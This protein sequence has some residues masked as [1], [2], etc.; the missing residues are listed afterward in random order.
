MR[1]LITYDGTLHAKTALR[2]GLG[3]VKEQGGEVIALFVFNPGLFIDYD[4]YPG[5]KETAR[6][7]SFRFVNEAKAMIQEAGDVKASVIVEDGDPEEETIRYARDRHAD[8]LFATPRFKSVIK[9]APCPVSVIPGHILVPVDN[10]EGVMAIMGRVIREARETESQVV[11]LGIVPE[12]IYSG[13]ERDELER[14]KKET[15][16]MV[17]MARKGFREAGIETKEIM[18]SGYPDEEMLKAAEEYTVSMILVPDG[19]DT[20]SE[21]N[22]AA[23]IILD[24]PDR[25]RRPVLIVPKSGTGQGF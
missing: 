22:K 12:H 9:H 4:A 13:G 8:I 11:L 20:P 23:S 15:E 16:R 19:G 1:I 5:V 6:R 24:E 2:Y 21:L 10:T 17:S 3:K 14:V 18:S 25:L 7:E